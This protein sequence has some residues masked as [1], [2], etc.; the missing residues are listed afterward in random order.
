AIPD[1]QPYILLL[2]KRDL[3]RCLTE[4]NN[5]LV[6][7]KVVAV[8]V[9]ESGLHQFAALLGRK[10][11]AELFQKICAAAQGALSSTPDLV[12]LYRA[13]GSR[14][15]EFIPTPYPVDDRRWD[16]SVPVPERRGLFI[17]TREFDVPSRNHA[18]A[19]LLAKTLDEPITVSNCDG[20]AGRK[21]LAEFGIPDANIIEAPMAY[22]AY[23]RVVAPHRLILQLDRSAVPGQV[24]GDAL[25][26][27]VPCV[28]GDSAIERVAF[29]G[30]C[31]LGRDFSETFE[32]AKRLLLDESC[33]KHEIESARTIAAARLSFSA[34]AGELERFFAALAATNR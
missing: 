4:L 2:L 9:K 21:R 28:G 31:G 23:L 22:P 8:S 27:G 29:P 20:R 18:A 34:T 12:E 25:L 13:A 32:I 5:L 6:A 3:K 33:M 11:N 7:G 19:L 15:V 17:G 24:A 26:C 30:L 14:N 1:S 16:F 10:G